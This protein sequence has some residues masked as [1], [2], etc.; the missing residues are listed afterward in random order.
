MA[1]RKKAKTKAKRKKALARK[2]VSRKK[3]V[4][5]A[6]KKAARKKPAARRAAPRKKPA[7][8][9]AAPK[10]KPATR[11]APKARPALAPQA[12]AGVPAPIP[13]EQRVGTVTHYYSHLSVAVV[14]LDSGTLCVGDMIHVTGHTTDFRQKV[15]SMQIEHESVSEC[16]PGDDFGLK[17]IDHAREN[18][19]VYKVPA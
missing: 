8:R 5:K 13:G 16:R 6:A 2:P 9:R 19:I 7:A 4:R 18:D 10:K 11:L 14:R 17:V 1:T 3:V 15:E 12:P